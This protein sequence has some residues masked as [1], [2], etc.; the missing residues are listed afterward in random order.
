MGKEKV[1]NKCKSHPRTNSTFNWIFL[2]PFINSGLRD[3][4]FQIHH[5]FHEG[6][7]WVSFCK[8]MKSRNL[9]LHRK[10]TLI[11]FVL[12]NTCQRVLT[13]TSL[14]QGFLLAEK[15]SQVRFLLTISK[16]NLAKTHKMNRAKTHNQKYMFL[17]L[18]TIRQGLV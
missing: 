7:G 11:P 4:T 17:A 13:E 1:Q 6:R 15:E 5:R 3:T 10:S 8:L 14:Y 2:S 9:H 16:M 12:G 18:P